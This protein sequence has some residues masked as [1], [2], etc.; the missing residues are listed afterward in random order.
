M[1]EQR[2]GRVYRMGQQKSVQAIYFV[3]SESI[4]ERI[5]SLVSQKKALFSGIFDEKIDEIHFAKTQSPSFIEKVTMIVPEQS[6]MT[7]EPQPKEPKEDDPLQQISAVEDSL[8]QEPNETLSYRGDPSS[9]EEIDLTPLLSAA[10][11]LLGNSKPDQPAAQ[12]LKIR[13]SKNHDTLHL[14]LPKPVMELLKGF[15]PLLET[16]LKLG[17]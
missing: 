3:S 15:K 6:E 7:Q 2:V 13:V 12:N 10:G 5:L 11:H 17:A 4:E 16:L 9:V 14:S 8:E 1:L